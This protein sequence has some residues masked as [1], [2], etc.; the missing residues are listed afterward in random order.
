MAVLIP[1]ATMRDNLDALIDAQWDPSTFTLRLW[2]S[3]TEPS[4]TDTYATYTQATFSGYV[5]VTPMVNNA[6]ITTVLGISEVI[7]DHHVWQQTALTVVN[8]VY[9]WMITSGTAPN[10]KIEAVER[11]DAPITLNA[12]GQ[13][14]IV[15]P[16]MPLLCESQGA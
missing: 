1:S 12:I 14:I 7:F 3:D 13:A 9:G 2:Q 10:I 8:T 15:E 6:N 4:L 11:F 16:R 5:A